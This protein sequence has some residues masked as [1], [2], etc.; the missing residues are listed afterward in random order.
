MFHVFVVYFMFHKSIEYEF[1]L[2]GLETKLVGTNAGHFVVWCLQ[3]VNSIS[4]VYKSEIFEKK[5]IQKDCIIIILKS[6]FGHLVV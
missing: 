2:K 4:V 1:P 5:L 6:V 3:V